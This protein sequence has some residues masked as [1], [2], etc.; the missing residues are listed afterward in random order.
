MNGLADRLSRL[1]VG[2]YPRRW[3]RRYGDEL[4]ALLDEHRSGPRT[5]ASLALGA[6]GTH[7]DPAYRRE[8]IAMSGL[9][10]PLRTAAK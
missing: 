5:V 6:L 2:C 4:R 9:R 7:L 8:G 3:R 1:M 10:D